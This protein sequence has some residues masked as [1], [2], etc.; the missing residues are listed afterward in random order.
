MSLRGVGSLSLDRCLSPTLFGLRHFSLSPMGRYTTR[1]F[2]LPPFDQISLLNA[3]HQCAVVY[4]GFFFFFFHLFISFRVWCCLV[5]GFP[6]L[7]RSTSSMSHLC[8]PDVQIW[9]FIVDVCV[10]CDFYSIFG[11]FSLVMGWACPPHHL[12]CSTTTYM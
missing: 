1:G 5:I 10:C 3:S 6:S 11:G 4:I 2:S 12:H 9:V 8:T 7:I